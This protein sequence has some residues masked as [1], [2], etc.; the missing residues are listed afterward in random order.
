MSVAKEGARAESG[1][2]VFEGRLSR[3]SPDQPRNAYANVW[4]LPGPDDGGIGPRQGMVCGADTLVLISVFPS[5][6][7]LMPGRRRFHLAIPPVAAL[8]PFS[9]KSTECAW[10]SLRETREGGEDRWRPSCSLMTKNPC[11]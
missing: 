11:G 6:R 8:S 3:P 7:A 1:M 10:C 5:P 2:V 9:Y 4:R